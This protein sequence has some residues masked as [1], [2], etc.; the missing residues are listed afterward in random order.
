M[1]VSVLATAC[2]DEEHIREALDSVRMQRTSFELEVLVSA[3]LGSQ[4]LEVAS[5][6]GDGRFEAVGAPVQEVDGRRLRRLIERAK[7][8]YVA[9]LH[10]CD[11]WLR[12]DKLQ[13]QVEALEARRDLSVCVHDT[14]LF[15]EDGSEPATEIRH[16]S[17]LDLGGLLS[18]R[19]S[20]D[21]SSVVIRRRAPDVYPAW[22]WDLPEADPALHVLDGL[23]GI[24]HLPVC[25]SA[26]RVRKGTPS[27]EARLLRL[28][29]RL[30]LFER[31]RPLVAS[32]YLDQ[33]EYASSNARALIAVEH[34]IPF[35][36]SVLVLSRGDEQL[37]ELGGRIA[38]HFPADIETYTG[39]LPADGREAVA[40]LQ[41][42]CAEGAQYVVVPA[43][44]RWW[45]GQYPDLAA[46]LDAHHERVF[47]DADAVVYRLAAGP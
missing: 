46:Y 12:E 14:I 44:A 2:D 26:S 8:K 31:V 17:P 30:A 6:Y 25:A 41:R 16:E 3:T 32:S 29:G 42:G 45:L 39:G 5:A 15:H 7:G 47:V 10:T 35:D 36:A 18:V 22:V 28:E 38:R 9:R 1:K 21:P 20:L 43:A 13:L 11:C 4:G 40:L 19:E 27:C 33:L 24:A 37:V 34:V 23:A